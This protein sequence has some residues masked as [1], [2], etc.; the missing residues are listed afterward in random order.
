MLKD[1]NLR[2]IPQSKEL[3]KL[4]KERPAIQRKEE[5]DLTK[6]DERLEWIRRFRP[7]ALSHCR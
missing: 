2:K 4:A 7:E 3:K 5:L 1:K 6:D